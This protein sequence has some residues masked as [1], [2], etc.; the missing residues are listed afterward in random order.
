[1]ILTERSAGVVPDPA[2]HPATAACWRALGTVRDPELDE[3]I[4]GLGF[5]AE[6]STSAV[7][8]GYAVRVRLRLPTFFCAPNFAWLMVADASDALRRV[9][10]VAA[11]DLALVDHF[12]AAQINEGVAASAGYASRFGVAGEPNDDPELAELRRM[13][14]VKAHRAAQDRLARALAADGVAGE[15]LVR[16]TLRESARRAPEPTAALVRRRAAVGLDTGP[17]APAIADDDGRPVPVDRLPTW[18]RLARATRVSIDGNGALCRG[19]LD[20]RYGQTRSM[21][22][23]A[24]P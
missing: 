13:F 20:T 2:W 15:E 18:L 5:V 4:T 10:G 16:L 19:L 12:A 23:M 14:E 6:L 21:V 3:P 1:V 11:V 22:A 9:E 7:D 24:Q 17:D 8:A